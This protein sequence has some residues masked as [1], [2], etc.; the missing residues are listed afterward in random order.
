MEDNVLN[1]FHWYW[2][3]ILYKYVYILRFLNTHSTFSSRDILFRT[4]LYI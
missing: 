1:S 4:T 2:R 3:H